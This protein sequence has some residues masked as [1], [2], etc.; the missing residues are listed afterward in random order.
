LRLLTPDGKAYKL[1]V[2]ISAGK[3]TNQ[4]VNLSTLPSE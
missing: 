3:P 2:D 1:V 4:Q